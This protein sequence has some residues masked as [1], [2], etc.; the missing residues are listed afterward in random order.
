MAENKTA[1][2]T[3][4]DNITTETNTVK[5]NFLDAYSKPIIYAGSALIILLG[6]YFGYQKLVKEPK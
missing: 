5:K 4:E 6:A 1:V 3:T 2:V